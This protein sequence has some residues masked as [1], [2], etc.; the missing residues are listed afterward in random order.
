M[1]WWVPRARPPCCFVWMD[2]SF[3]TRDHWGLG[4][5]FQRVCRFATGFVHR[6]STGDSGKKRHWLSLLSWWVWDIE[7]EDFLLVGFVYPLIVFK[8]VRC[9]FHEGDCFQLIFIPLPILLAAVELNWLGLGN[10]PAYMSKLLVFRSDIWI[11]KVGRG[12]STLR[13]CLLRFLGM[14]PE[15]PEWIRWRLVL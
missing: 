4:N 1:S 13:L 3:I 10:S 6:I 5:A 12:Y 8:G 7:L 9:L 14:S 15:M 2:Q 11:S